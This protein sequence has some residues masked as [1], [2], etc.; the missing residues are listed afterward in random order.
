[1]EEH[2]LIAQLKEG[3]QQAY[4]YLVNYY[5]VAVY[6]T[7][8]NLLQD[9]DEADD[10]AQ[11]VFVKVFNAINQFNGQSSLSTW[12]Y[13]IAVRKAI[14][15]IRQIKAKRAL[16]QLLLWPQAGNNT[17]NRF[18]HPGVNLEH[19]EKAAILFKAIA[20]L[21]EKQKAAF[22]LIKVQ[23]LSY[24]EASEI[25]QMSIK[26]LESLISRAKN[27]LQKDLVHYDL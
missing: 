14:D 1:M 11:D 25:M 26:A 9:T 27:N 16:L 19:K 10:I 18:E 23:E 20:R 24:Q 6:N 4:R 3:N 12:I 22:T 17:N 13:R 7:V 2:I 5:R 8:L 15:R 21:P